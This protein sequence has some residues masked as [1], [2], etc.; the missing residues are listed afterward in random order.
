MPK[1]TKTRR[2]VRVAT[3]SPLLRKADDA[4]RAAFL[5][6]LVDSYGLRA[7]VE[8]VDGDDADAGSVPPPRIPDLFRA[9]LK[10]QDMYGNEYENW[11]DYIQAATDGEF[12]R[13]SGIGPGPWATD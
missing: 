2:D 13:I 8:A 9:P 3:L 4:Q 6:L 11:Y 12:G 7:V 1:T 10:F 5:G